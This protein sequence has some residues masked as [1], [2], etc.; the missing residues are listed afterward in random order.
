MPVF[1]IHEQLTLYCLISDNVGGTPAINGSSCLIYSTSDT[2]PADGVQCV[3]CEGHMRWDFET[4]DL[5][6]CI[7]K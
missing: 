4:G 7:R 3:Q 1:I 6:D 5:G 2:T